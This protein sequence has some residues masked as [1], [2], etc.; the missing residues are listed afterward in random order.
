MLEH[1]RLKYN[2]LHDN[3]FFSQQPIAMNKLNTF[4]IARTGK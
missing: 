3:V 1:F 2:T 4:I